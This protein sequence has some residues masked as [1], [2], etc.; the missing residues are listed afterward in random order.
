MFKHLIFLFSTHSLFAVTILTVTQSTDNGAGSDG[1]VGDLR[2]YINLMNQSLNTTPDDYEIKF[3]F[4]M[5]IQLNGILPIINNSPHPVSITI[6]NPGSIPTVTIDGNGGAYSGFF[7]PMGNVTIQNMIFQ[8]LTAQGGTGGDGISGGGGGMGAGGAIYAPQAFLNGSDP[9]ITLMNVSINSCS[10]QG[11]N[12]GNYIGGGS[13]GDEGGGGG[14][15]FSGNGGSVTTTGITGGAGGGGFGGNGGNVTRTTGDPNGGGGG[16]GGGI[17]ARANLFPITNSG[18]GGSDQDNGEGGSCY[19]LTTAAGSGGG[20]NTG[21]NN[22]GGGG[23]GAPYG[24]GGGGS[25]GFDGFQPLGTTPP[26]GAAA[27][28]GGSGGDGGGGGGAGVV[29]TGASNSVDG[30]A[31]TGGYGGGGGGGAGTGFTDPGYTVRGGAGGLGGGGGGGGVNQSNTTPAEGG[32]SGGGGG[33]GGGG[34]S[35]GATAA[36]GTDGGNL[37]GGAGGDGSS[38]YGMGFGGGGGGGG[39]GLGGA[40]FVDTGLN[41]TIQALPGISTTF[42]TINTTVQAGMQGTGGPGSTPAFGGTALGNSIFLRT[43]SSL[44]LIANDSNDL[45]TLGDGVSFVDDT[46]LGGGVTNVYI[47]GNGTV[48]YNGSSNYQGTIWINN[49]NFK[50]NQLIDQASVNVCRNL[51]FSSQRGTLSGS[52]TLTGNVFANSGIISPDTT[53]TLGLLILS[54]ADPVGG[55]LGS[56]VHI[57]IDSGGTT[58]VAVTGTAAL[59]GTLE[60]DISSDALPGLYNVLTS[61]GI[62]GTFDSVEFTGTTPNY[63]LSYLP[64]GSPTFVQFNFLGFPISNSTLSTQGLQGNNLNVANYLNLLSPNANALGLTNQLSL[65][66]GLSPSQYQNALESISPSRNSIS[67]FASQNVMFMLTGSLNSRFTKTRL[68]RNHSA[69]PPAEATAFVVENEL[70]AAE[71]SPRKTIYAPPKNTN[72]QFWMMS[73][74]Q[75]GSQ[76]SQD[77]TPGFGFNSAGF[78]T[79]YDYGNSEQGCIGALAGYAHSSIH[80][81]QSMGNS[82][83]NAGYFSIYGTRFF[84]DFFLEAAVYGEYMG[85]DQKRIISYPGF[86]GTAKS[87]YHAEQIDLHFGT[88]YDVNINTVTIEPFGL[89]DWVYEWIPSYTEKGGAPYNMKFPSSTTWML[90]FETGLN[91]YKTNTYAWGT[92]IAQAKLSYVYKKPHQVGH[93]R[94]AIVDAPTSFVVEAFTSAQSLVSPAI[95]LFWQTNW[96]GYGSI[97]YDGEFGSGYSSNQFY[98][99]IGYSF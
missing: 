48:V 93:I 64:I 98:G 63:S 72:S 99:K 62:T 23:G 66:N 40:I 24:G 13:T 87:S 31:G 56:L 60:I 52:G 78:L 58:S 81:D 1:E 45:L 41:F 57:G 35:N 76:D 53:L 92:F 49:A 43:M 18:N 42:N 37:G 5:T 74:G 73:F 59:A 89:L 46:D 94:A 4:P 39:S 97:S 3:A 16:G 9:S 11:G 34:P 71:Q 68:A 79:G 83:L 65:L 67:T 44:T 32:N 33:G 12:G 22:L 86:K 38:T 20:G 47:R 6:G 19:G 7:I 27:A 28:S 61:S 10:A 88:G 95:E 55:S 17:G 84:S 25:F 82:H 75:F 29:N 26:G 30:Q 51:G 70:I 54:A 91:G 90:R 80:A 85:V 69:S 14:G 2:Y 77:Q 36:G 15:G 50:V 21:G 96:N 8:N